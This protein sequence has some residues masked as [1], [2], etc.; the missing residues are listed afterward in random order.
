[1]PDTFD[2]EINNM[3]REVAALKQVREK[4]ANTLMTQSQSVTLN[5]SLELVTTGGTPM[6]RSDKMAIIDI[7]TGGNNP[8]VGVNYSVTGLNNRVIRDIPIYNQNTGHI[9]RMVFIVSNNSSDY[10]TLAGGGSV[11]LTYNITLSSTASVNLSTSY[12]DLWVY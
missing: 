9:G 12:Q 4:A 1:M 6:V 8:L 2:T 3:E 10:S 5:F 11:N 7:D